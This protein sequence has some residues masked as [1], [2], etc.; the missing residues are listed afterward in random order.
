MNFQQYWNSQDLDK[1][2][3]TE[4]YCRASWNTCKLEILKTLEQNTELE[5]ISQ[6]GKKVYKIYGTVIDKIKNEI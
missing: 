3:S 5:A 6:N 4:D 2:R 1:Y